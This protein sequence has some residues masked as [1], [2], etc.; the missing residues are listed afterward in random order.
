MALVRNAAN[1]KAVAAMWRIFS[2][3]RES[4]LGGSF[5]GAKATAVCADAFSAEKKT[6]MANNLLIFDPSTL[7]RW[8]SRT[9]ERE[10]S[11]I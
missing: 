2:F 9:R 7:N 10:V 11:V 3:R 8:H 1:S 4:N 6:S 5:R